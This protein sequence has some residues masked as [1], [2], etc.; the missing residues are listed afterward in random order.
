MTVTETPSTTKDGRIVAIVGPVVDVEFPPGDLPELYGALDFTVD[1]AG[2]TTVIT[3]EVAQH[4]GDSRVRAICHAS[5]PTA[6]SG[7]SR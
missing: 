5:R 3:A 1:I 6:S 7:A 2:E 4:I